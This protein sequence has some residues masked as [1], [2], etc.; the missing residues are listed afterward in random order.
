M[1]ISV[2]IPAFNEENYITACLTH[3]F[4]QEELPDEVI[5]VDNN[6]T[7]KTVEFAKKFP[8]K[9]MTEKNQGITPTRDKG[10]NAAKYSIIGRI[11]ADTLLPP[12]WIKEVKK[13]FELDP[14]LIAFSGATIFK[15]KHLDKLLKVPGMIYYASFKKIM[16][17]DCLYGPNMAI[18]K[19]AWKKVRSFT[20]T[21][22]KLV[23]E[24]ADLAIH[25]A[26]LN[27]GKIIFDP[28]FLV[29]VSDRRWKKINYS[30]IEYP[31]RY[32]KM[33]AKHQKSLKKMSQNLNTIKNIPNYILQTVKPKNVENS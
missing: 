30:Y 22:D 11:D 26:E 31:Y 10:F 32:L 24:D 19:K 16:G 14:K 3:L 25:L 20:C 12:H 5:V 21:D 2:V 9:I 15:N 4:K 33:I 7:D 1:K 18:R 6:S 17:C 29:N 8:V 27:L 23:H 13:R 28:H